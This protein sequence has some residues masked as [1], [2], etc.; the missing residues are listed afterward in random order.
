[1]VNQRKVSTFV[2]KSPSPS[3]QQVPCFW[4]LLHHREQRPVSSLSSVAEN[5]TAGR[6]TGYRPQPPYRFFHFFSPLKTSIAL[7]KRRTST[8]HDWHFGLDGSLWWGG[9][10]VRGG[11]FSSI[12][13]LC[14]LM[15][16][17]PI[18]QY[19]HWW[20]PTMS[21]DTAKGPN[22]PRGWSS[23]WRTADLTYPGKASAGPQGGLKHCS[24]HAYTD[25]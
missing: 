18:L 17:P 2:P 14:P 5:V 1:M 3:H 11:M 4:W 24:P 6:H 12:P 7:L 8:S 13:G 25:Q 9:C 19:P 16:G 21:V 22:V 23:R 20:W 15:L 10:A